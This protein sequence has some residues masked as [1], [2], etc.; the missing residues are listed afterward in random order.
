MGLA[1]LIQFAQANPNKVRGKKLLAIVGGANM[2]FGK[3]A[4]ISSQSAVG[5]HKRRY[6]RLHIG[7][8]KGGLLELLEK[9]FSDVNVS[10]FQ[11][12]KTGHT[13][14]WPV[15]GFEATPEK[16]DALFAE[17]KKADLPYE[18]V[19]GNADVRYR[20]IPYT[21]ML[22][23]LPL[24]FHVHFPERRGALRDFMRRIS[25]VANL[26]YFNYAYSGES[27]GRAIMG[28]EFASDADQKTFLELIKDV[29]V[30][31]RP[32]DPNVAHRI[33]GS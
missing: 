13:D 19:T 21:P 17:L 10:E 23:S 29:P 15:I 14:G 30:T 11:Y 28:F 12:G 1:G 24:F 33:L 18:D 32:L 4:L 6:L 16:F 31:C 20:I 8:K 9:H 7:E 22:F 3:L 26:C 5:A 27:I 2:D 25:G